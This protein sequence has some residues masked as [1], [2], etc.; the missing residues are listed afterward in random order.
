MKKFPTEDVPGL[1]TLC[2]GGYHGR[3]RLEPSQ[4]PVNADAAERERDKSNPGAADSIVP[5]L[6]QSARTGHPQLY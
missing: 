6:A 1:D 3:I 4:F 5:A 2:K